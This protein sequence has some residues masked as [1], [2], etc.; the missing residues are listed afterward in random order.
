MGA[1]G[2]RCE[3]PAHGSSVSG[4]GALPWDVRQN[5]A[6][7]CARERTVCGQCS[8][9]LHTGSAGVAVCGDDED[10]QACS[11]IEEAVV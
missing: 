10:V 6:V 5:A 7:C 11:K 4:D 9:W 2:E 1:E 3:N 8:A